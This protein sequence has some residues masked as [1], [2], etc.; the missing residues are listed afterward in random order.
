VRA[1]R[2]G[3]GR[4][5]VAGTTATNRVDRCVVLVKEAVTLELLIEGEHGTLAGSVDVSGP[6]ATTKEA[7]GVR[8]G[9]LRRRRRERSSLEAVVVTGS[10]AARVVEAAGGVEGRGLSD[11]GHFE[12]GV[13]LLRS[14][15]DLLRWELGAC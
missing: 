10:A 12:G 8:G 13:W 4:N 9:D 3:I 1:G 5:N 7:V 15:E 2:D 14:F 11:D 6:A